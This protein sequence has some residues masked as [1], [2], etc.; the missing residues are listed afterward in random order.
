[1]DQE[2]VSSGNLGARPGK[3]EP[4]QAGRPLG[5]GGGT[6]RQ[7]RKKKDAILVTMSTDN[8]V[9]SRDSGIDDVESDF[10]GSEGKLEKVCEWC[11]KGFRQMHEWGGGARAYC[12][13]KCRMS[14][15]QD[16]KSRAEWLL[17]RVLGKA[18]SVIA[19]NKFN[20]D[21]EIDREGYPGRSAVTGEW[22]QMVS[23]AEKFLVS[24][25]SAVA[26]GLGGNGRGEA[27]EVT[28]VEPYDGRPSEM[29]R[30]E[31]AP[32]VK[33]KPGRPLKG[34]PREEYG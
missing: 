32:V 19:E 12:S 16:G 30:E 2:I 7:L 27:L 18:Y 13:G 29:R 10:S 26:N 8:P 11:G 4:P 20:F 15:Y 34:P 17:M 24:T 14:G 25:E 1:M 5:G 21:L 6:P 22:K 28:E 33:R 3:S 31:A 9:D 23:W